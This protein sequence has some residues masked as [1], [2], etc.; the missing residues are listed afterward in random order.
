[1]IETRYPSHENEEVLTIKKSI[2]GLLAGKYLVRRS[3]GLNNVLVNEA[4][5]KPRIDIP[6]DSQIKVH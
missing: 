4:R 5:M 3:P 1:M 6:C 2:I